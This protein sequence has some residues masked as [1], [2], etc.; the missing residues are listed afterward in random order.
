MTTTTISGAL[1]SPVKHDNTAIRSLILCLPISPPFCS[2]LTPSVRPYDKRFISVAVFRASRLFAMLRRHVMPKSKLFLLNQGAH[3]IW[4][5]H[6]TNNNNSEYGDQAI[7]EE[8]EDEEVG[9]EKIEPQQTFLELCC[10]CCSALLRRLVVGVI[11]I[12]DAC[13][14]LWIV[15]MYVHAFVAVR[16]WRTSQ[17]GETDGQTDRTGERRRG[18]C[19][20]NLDEDDD[21]NEADNN[22]FAR[23]ID[24][25]FPYPLSRTFSAWCSRQCG[26]CLDGWLNLKLNIFANNA[27]CAYHHRHHFILLL[28]HVLLLLIPYPC[29][30]YWCAADQHHHWRCRHSLRVLY[31]QICVYVWYLF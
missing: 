4:G 16:R 20:W 26:Y 24:A 30:C 3:K 5:V 23:S 13:K 1:W 12:C 18:Q 14:Y 7:E 17:D 8:E 15:R 9:R 25:P 2:S 21:E 22:N 27:F 29:S 28:S 6:N 11:I 19:P 10:C 31:I